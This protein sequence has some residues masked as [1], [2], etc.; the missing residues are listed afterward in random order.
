MTVNRRI[1]SDG[2]AAEV[3]ANQLS[4]ALLF[5]SRGR[6]PVAI[7]KLQDAFVAWNNRPR[8]VANLTGWLQANTEN[9]LNWQIVST[10]SEP[11]EWLDAPMLYFASH[12]RIS[13]LD[14]LPQD[15]NAYIKQM[16][17]LH[18]A[19]A[20]GQVIDAPQAPTRPKIEPIDKLRTYL[21]LGGML[22]AVNEGKGH[23]FADSIETIGS[24]MYPQYDWRTLPENHWAYTI[25]LP[26][27][28]KRPAL[29]GLSNG[30]REL[31]ILSPS[32]DLSAT[33][34]TR[35]TTERNHYRTAAN[36]YFYASELNRP[37]PR[38]APHFIAANDDQDDDSRFEAEL[39]KATI[40]QAIH[41]DNW[42]VEPQALT[43]FR[44][45][46]RS[47]HEFDI[48]LI[49][50]QLARIDQIRP[51]PDLVV[52]SGVD[53]HLFSTAQRAALRSYINSGGVVLFETPGGRGD[54]T[55]SAEQACTDIFGAPIRSLI[56]HRIVT[57][58]GLRGAA[59][60]NRLEYRPYS[61]EVFGAR[62]TMPRLRGMIIDGQARVLFSREDIS[63]AL[64]DQPC[65]GIAG[66]KPDS[67]KRLLANILHHTR[68]LSDQ[69]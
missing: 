55:L 15:T 6:V 40:A 43:V 69:P 17:Q 30:V 60:L 32:T 64:L 7:N 20:A 33:F 31:I 1:A 18:R 29:R 68:A 2:R 52:V 44:A 45:A 57:G 21:D 65:W 42:D 59:R 25:L 36:V 5:L 49:E 19:R 50:H 61:F 27:L 63:H 23:G 9:A 48:T 34:Q 11:Y 54:F 4:F 16:R 56:R 8:D 3:R 37:R 66:Y 22:F 53:A 38:L 26:V 10:E 58:R 28:S 13:W 12:Q 24:V 51:P 67:A 14:Q 41:E 46:M 39:P 35:L 47:Q 62:E